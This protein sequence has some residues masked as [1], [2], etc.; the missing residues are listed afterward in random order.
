MICPNCHGTGHK[1]HHVCTECM[2]SGSASCCDTAGASASYEV[3]GAHCPNC[4]KWVDGA[5]GVSADARPSPGDISICIYCSHLS[6]YADDLTLRHLTDEE[7][8]EIAGD[9]HI[10]AAMRAIE[11]FRKW[12]EAKRDD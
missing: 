7:M 11:Q 12:K 3:P 4:G 8:I 1:G 9:K 2:G 6:A 10:L 5:T